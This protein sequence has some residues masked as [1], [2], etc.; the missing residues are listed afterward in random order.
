MANEQN[1]KFA[2]IVVVQGK[3]KV[4]EKFAKGC[5]SDGKKLQNMWLKIGKGIG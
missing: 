4:K 5:D 1:G 2:D 3:R